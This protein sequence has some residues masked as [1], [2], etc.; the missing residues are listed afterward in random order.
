M[1]KPSLEELSSM[2]RKGVSLEEA[3]KSL[4][5]KDF[6]GVVSDAFEANGFRTMRNLRFSHEKRRYEV[7][8]VALER[9]RLVAVD[10]KH[11]GL[12]AGKGSALRAASL[13]QLKRAVNLGK[14]AQ[15][16]QGID[17]GGWGEVTLVPCI[18]TLYEERIVESGGVLVVPLA[19]LNSF[20]EELR[21]GYFDFLRAKIMTMCSWMQ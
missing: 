14:K 9:P 15:E 11:W 18:V 5:W 8:V 7:D 1:G 12:R 3:T 16:V 4:E 2:L 13:A 17:I 21:S 10:C 20:I 6:E 19:K